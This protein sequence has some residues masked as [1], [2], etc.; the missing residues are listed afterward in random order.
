MEL[1]LAISQGTGVALATGLRSFLPPLLVSALARANLGIDFEGT[2]Y[3][4]LESIPFLV[5]LL[6]LNV[7][8][9]L[10]ERLPARRPLQL[11][12][13]LAAIVLGA[14]MF[15]G[16]LADDG[17]EPVPG[18]AAGAVCVVIAYAAVQTFLGRARARLAA[19]GEDGSAGYLNLYADG[20]AL[21]LAA[22]AVLAPP[23]SYL[24]LAFCLWVL[25]ERR[26]RS[27]RKYEGLRVLR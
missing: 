10:S 14:L 3:A 8:G 4:F 16:S 7:V 2:D 18:L 17:Y 12:F 26:R 6:F 15:A 23:I 5:A 9:V 21:G 19:R 13:L 27:G 24:A 25:V 22:L 11:S 1:F 20:A